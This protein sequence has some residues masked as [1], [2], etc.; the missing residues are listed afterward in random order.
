VSL[1]RNLQEFSNNAYRYNSPAPYVNNN[2]GWFVPNHIIVVTGY[3]TSYVY[4]ND[5]LRYASTSLPSPANYAIPVAMFKN[6]ASTTPWTSTTN[7][8]AMSVLR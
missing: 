7:W 3:N 1:G 8:Y 5:P 2:D 6:A 4:I